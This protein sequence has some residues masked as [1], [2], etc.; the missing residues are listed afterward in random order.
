MSQASLPRMATEILGM[1]A[2]KLDDHGLA[3][4]RVT[5]R[6]L[7]QGSTYEFAQR[8][9]SSRIEILCTRDSDSMR[10]LTVT[11]RSSNLIKARA[12]MAEILEL[13]DPKY[14]EDS[15]SPWLWVKSTVAKKFI[16]S[17]T[18]TSN[19]DAFTLLQVKNYRQNHG[20]CL[21]P[22]IFGRIAFLLPAQTTNLR[23]LVIDNARMDGDALIDVFETHKH[24]LRHMTLRQVTITKFIK[25]FQALCRTEAQRFEVD[26]LATRDDL[27]RGSYRYFSRVHDAFPYFL[28]TMSEPDWKERLPIDYDTFIYER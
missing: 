24:Q 9:T 5:C 25:C 1:I 11:L 21:A 14:T 23:R 17:H 27:G 26:R 18:V 6:D 13:H 4:M 3:S 8:H 2:S 10:K 19:P 28:R 20:F 15:V 22:L 12:T 7:L 16:P